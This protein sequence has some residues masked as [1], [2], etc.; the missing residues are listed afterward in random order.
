M[1]PPAPTL[2]ALPA[3]APFGHC[4]YQSSTEQGGTAG[5]LALLPLPAHLLPGSRGA[6]R[7]CAFVSEMGAYMAKMLLPS[8]S[9]VVFLPAA[10]VAAKRGFHMEAMVYFFTMFFS[11]VRSRPHG[12]LSLCDRLC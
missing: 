2:V 12:L 5:R 7:I 6:T 9:S 1:T 4:R 11:A 3:R 8:V 10:S